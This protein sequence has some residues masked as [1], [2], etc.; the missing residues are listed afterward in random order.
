MQTFISKYSRSLL[1]GSSALVALAIA[2]I[3]THQFACGD[4]Y[5]VSCDQTEPYADASI[6]LAPNYY[7][8]TDQTFQMAKESG[9]T[10]V[11]Y[12]WAPWCVTCTSLDIELEEEKATIPEDL[13]VLR[14]N[15]DKASQLKKQYNIVTQ[16]TF[17]QLDSEGNAVSSWVGGDIENFDTYLKR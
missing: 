12:F 4:V 14:I 5:A 10:I 15:Y 8:Y 2:G 6:E 1:V 7:T 3:G 16:H 9:K 13:I 17:V 11:L